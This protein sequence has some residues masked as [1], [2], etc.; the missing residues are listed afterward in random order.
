MYVQDVRNQIS[1]LF[2]NTTPMAENGV[3]GSGNA[4][5]LVHR[6][7]DPSE[8][9][10]DRQRTGLLHVAISH[11][12]NPMFARVRETNNVIGTTPTAKP[13]L[14]TSTHIRKWV[15][16]NRVEPGLMKSGF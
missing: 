12:A 1:L 16:G 13:G 15:D 5:L 6:V 8:R 2:M 11:A 7:R 14:I 9:Q 10:K 4:V 3:P